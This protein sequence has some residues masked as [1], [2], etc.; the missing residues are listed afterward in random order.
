MLACVWAWHIGNFAVKDWNLRKYDV[1]PLD[2]EYVLNALG[3]KC[4]DL[5]N[6]VEIACGCPV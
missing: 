4:I 1:G 6:N 2:W 5:T 3:T